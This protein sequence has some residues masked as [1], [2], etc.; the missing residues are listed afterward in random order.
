MTRIH[1]LI[2]Q[3]GTVKYGETATLQKDLDNNSKWTEFWQFAYSFIIMLSSTF[4]SPQSLMDQQRKMKLVAICTTLL[5]VSMIANTAQGRG[6][7]HKIVNRN[8][9][10]DPFWYVNR[11]VRPIG[12]FGKRQMASS[13]NRR[14]TMNN[15]ELILN[16]LR[17][18]DAFDS[19]QQQGGDENY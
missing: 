13:S 16:A 10:I 8:T 12:R 11:G 2:K 4:C 14:L 9:N 5:L 19:N 6:L 7:S 15:L 1:K 18:Q 17:E 3:D